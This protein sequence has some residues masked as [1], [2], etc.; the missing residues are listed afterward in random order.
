MAGAL[1]LDP[2]TKGTLHLECWDDRLR[3]HGPCLGLKHAFSHAQLVVGV[4]RELHEEAGEERRWGHRGSE[5]E[6]S[7][8][9]QIVKSTKEL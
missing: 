9:T 6:I 2:R 8:P 3:P 5:K 1:Q 4:R 7:R